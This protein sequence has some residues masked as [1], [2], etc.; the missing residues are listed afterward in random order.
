[1]YGHSHGL[2]VNLQTLWLTCSDKNVIVALYE[3]LRFLK[4]GHTGCNILGLELWTVHKRT[5]IRMLT[6]LSLADKSVNILKQALN[7]GIWLVKWVQ[8]ILQSCCP[9]YFIFRYLCCAGLV[10]FNLFTDAW[11][12]SDVECPFP[13]SI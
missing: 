10:Y 6:W 4:E 2:P 7:M 9:K 13:V 11:N 8:S 12:L 3:F 1:M 5:S